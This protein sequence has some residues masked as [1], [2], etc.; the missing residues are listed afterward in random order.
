MHS[1]RRWTTDCAD[2]YASL[3]RRTDELKAHT[4][5]LDRSKRPFLQVEHDLLRERLRQHLLDLAAF[6]RRLRSRFPRT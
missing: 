2:E 4:L 3:L 1:R 6:R 5:A